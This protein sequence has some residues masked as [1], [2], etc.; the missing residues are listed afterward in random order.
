MADLDLER[1]ERLLQSARDLFF[2]S[3]LAGVAGLA[4]QAFE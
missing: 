3:D 2:Q 1:A 4:Y